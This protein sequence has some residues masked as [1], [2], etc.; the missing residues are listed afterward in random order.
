[1]VE[2][3][4]V[5]FEDR[6]KVYHIKLQGSKFEVGDYCIVE[7]QKGCKSLGR[8]VECVSRVEKK[9][10]RKY[11]GRMIRK[12]TDEDLKHLEEVKIQRKKAID[13]ARSRIEQR[14]LEMNLVE[15]DYSFDGDKIIFYFTAERRVDFR[16]LVKDLAHEFRARIEMRQI[17]VRDEVKMFG[18]YGAC[19][20]A[21]C[22]ASFLQDFESVT[23]RMA[24]DQCI[25]LNPTK[26]S[27]ICGRLLCCLGYENEVYEELRK[28]L[29]QIGDNLIYEG[30]EGKVKQLN[31]IEQ[32]FNLEFSDGRV[33]KVKTKDLRKEELVTSNSS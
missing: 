22:C 1:M 29:P 18:G 23:M 3:V 32:T 17:G 13:F 21:L 25:S 24:K 33:I 16:E 11:I 19:G 27:G 6:D 4:G 10:L 9:K 12:A 20:R 31:I 8:V 5:K 14:K 2:F 28:S 30:E 26:I 7:I 15:V